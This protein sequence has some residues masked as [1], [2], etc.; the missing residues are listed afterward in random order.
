[1]DGRR[2]LIEKTLLK[3]RETKRTINKRQQRN[4]VT[5]RFPIANFLTNQRRDAKKDFF[6]DSRERNNSRI[7]RRIFSHG[8]NSARSDHAEV[9]RE[10]KWDSELGNLSH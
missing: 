3:E 8:N 1:M 5:R 9:C 4:N 10:T 7:T 2:E 6:P